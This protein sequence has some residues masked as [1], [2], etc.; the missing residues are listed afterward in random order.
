[1][2]SIKEYLKNFYASNEELVAEELSEQAENRGSTLIDEIE[3]GKLI[4]VTGVIKSVIVKPNTQ[5]PSYEVEVF[6]GSGNLTVIWQGRRKV[7][8]VE[9]G[10]QIEVE[11]RITF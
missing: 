2:K 10:T 3:R 9:P 11:G 6:D 8:G 1:M 4:Q 5:N 7:V